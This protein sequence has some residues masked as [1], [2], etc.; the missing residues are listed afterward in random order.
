MTQLTSLLQKQPRIHNDVVSL[1]R[2][3]YSP[4]GIQVFEE[5][6]TEPLAIRWGELTDDQAHY[7][8]FLL[9]VA[10]SFTG[11]DVK[12]E[13]FGLMPPIVGRALARIANE[14][15]IYRPVLEGLASGK[16]SRFEAKLLAGEIDIDNGRGIVLTIDEL[17]KMTINAA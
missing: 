15:R 3:L 9:D 8:L 1:L 10:E 14:L 12:P 6:A 11:I 13:M 17:K 7:V 4:E 2:L 16:L 5:M